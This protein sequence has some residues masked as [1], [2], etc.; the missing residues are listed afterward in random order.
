ML[1][2]LFI[3]DIVGKSGRDI[4]KK[5]LP[6]LKAEEHID[7]VI[8]NGENAAHGKG[9]T[10]KI[11]HE[12]IS[13]GIDVITM[14]N[15]TYSKHTIFDIISDHRLI[16]P[17]NLLPNDQGCGVRHFVVNGQKI[18]VINIMGKV[19]M[20]RVEMDPF[21]ALNSVS[22]KNIINI[23]DFHGEVTSEKIVFAHYFKS[24]L[25]AVIGTHTHVQTADERLIEN[26]AFISD[27]GMC[28]AYD[29]VLGRD[30]NEV[31]DSFIHKN[32]TH[33]KVADGLGIFC[34]VIIDIEG[35][36]ARSIKRIQ[37]RPY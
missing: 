21:L 2:V 19:F 36:E 33:Y 6:K 11:F 22:L 34:A 17:I 35:S 24:K 32:K 10:P 14:G 9:M 7:F 3:G 1:R 25:T 20:D 26:C 8:A 29:S 4:V 13:F 12:L 27:V 30:L 5:V 16:R 23:V 15:H 31:F 18:A 37:L 28:G